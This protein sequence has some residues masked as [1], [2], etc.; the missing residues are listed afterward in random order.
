MTINDL[1]EK[2]RDGGKPDEDRLFGVLSVRFLLF[3]CQRV[4]NEEDAKE[5]V[6]DSLTKIAGQYRGI[7]F[8]VSFSAWAY[9]V[10]INELR[11][12]VRKKVR[13]GDAVEVSDQPADSVGSWEPD[14]DLEPQLVDC[15]RK[16]VKR[17]VRY[18][19]I[20]N[21]RYQGYDA[22]AI[23]ARLGVSANNFYVILSRARAMLR[24]CLEKGE[25][26]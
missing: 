10:L 19:R 1:Y 4:C 6:Q 8:Q 17:N 25:V 22:D 23:C 18:A 2:A 12:F 14:P 3:A 15:V 5:I 21:L 13:R 11:N 24:E 20:L 16:L 7:D 26:Y 9:K